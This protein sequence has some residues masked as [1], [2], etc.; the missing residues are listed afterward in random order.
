MSG[1]TQAAREKLPG[2]FEDLVRMMP[3]RAI[4][5]DAQ[6]EVAVDMIDRL[7]ASGRLTRGQESYLE[8]L[9]QLVEVYE[10]AHHGI[11]TSGMKA[12]DSL[13]HLL[14]TNG[15]NASDLAKLLGVHPSMGSKLIK[16]DRSLTVS[17]L[18]KLAA[19]FKVSPELFID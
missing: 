13:T 11:D 9:V 15:M 14:A 8:T 2:R 10:G 3:P 7:M 17:H 6:L 18:R 4:R 12:I 16:G 19:R 1:T 5:D